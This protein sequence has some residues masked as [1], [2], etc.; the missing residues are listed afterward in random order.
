MTD[1]REGPPQRMDSGAI[2]ALAMLGEVFRAKG[3]PTGAAHLA[4]GVRVHAE[5][6]VMGL[7]YLAEC[8]FIVAIVPGRKWPERDTALRGLDWTRPHLL[9]VTPKG[10]AWVRG[11]I[12]PFAELVLEVVHTA[13]AASKRAAAS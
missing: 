4:R 3:T 11:Q 2:M 1:E 13:P 7:A 5:T 9:E 10:M 6:M 8:G 12:A